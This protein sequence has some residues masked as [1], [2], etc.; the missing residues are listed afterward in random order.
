MA[1]QAIDIDLFPPAKLH[2]IVRKPLDL[3][4]LRPVSEKAA[5]AK[6]TR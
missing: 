2:K 6:S 1:R 3:R 4:R 5:K